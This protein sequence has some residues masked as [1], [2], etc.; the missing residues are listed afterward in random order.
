MSINA[1]TCAGNVAINGN[2]TIG[3]ASS[4]T[5]TITASLA[6]TIPIGTTN[7]YDI[8]SST[9]G[10]RALYFGANSQTTKIV[11]SA[12]MAATWTLTLPTNVGTIG[13]FLVDSD[14]SGTSAWRYPEKTTSKTTTY[15]GTGDETVILADSS[16]GAFT[17]TLPAAASFTGKHYYIKKTSSDTNAVTIDGNSSETI[18]GSLTKLIYEQYEG[19][20]IVSDG[21][22]WHIL[23]RENYAV[24]CRAYLDG[25]TTV[26]SATAFIFSSETYDVKGIY[27]TSNGRITAT[28][29]GYY[30][31]AALITYASSAWTAG[32]TNAL[33]IHKNGSLYAYMAADDIQA[34]GTFVK[35]IQGKFEIQLAASDY[36]QIVPVFTG[37]RTSISTAGLNWVTAHLINS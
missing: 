10:L 34:S 12:S 3:N 7:S 1:L 27:N 13:Q 25:G 32:D 16:G 21:S 15:T 19:I 30:S 5:L 37:S 26:T 23:S 20:K 36:V 8:G 31:I 29:A 24:A 4:D 22:N 2:T 6:S 17:I 33:Q 28:E 35:Q 18:D 11:G 9:L 14:G